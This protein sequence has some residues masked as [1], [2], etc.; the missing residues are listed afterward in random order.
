MVGAAKEAALCLHCHGA[1]RAADIDW[2]AM[3]CDGAGCECQPAVMNGHHQ[4]R[5]SQRFLTAVVVTQH[6]ECHVQ[7]EALA[8]TD[9]G[10]HKVR[11]DGM[12]VSTEASVR[13]LHIA[14]VFPGAFREP[15]L[16]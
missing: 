15:G 2:I 1:D 6:P 10:G 11:I 9:S 3:R 13:G 14:G 8:E 7:V 4:S 16:G 12:V 5:A